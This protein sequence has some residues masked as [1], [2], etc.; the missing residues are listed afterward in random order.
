LLEAVVITVAG[1]VILAALGFG[2][3]WARRRI[4]ERR[5]WRWLRANT[6]DEPTRSHATVARLADGVRLPEERVLRACIASRRVFRSTGD[7]SLWSA[8]RAEPE[9][10]E[11]RIW[12][13]D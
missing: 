2:A 1:G 10:P 8:W 13:L 6:R 3:R 11:P 4:D 12:F 7:P 5:I 9:R